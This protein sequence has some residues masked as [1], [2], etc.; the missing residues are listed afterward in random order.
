MGKQG[1]LA[2][3]AAGRHLLKDDAKIIGVAVS[4]KK[5][6][7]EQM[8]T[9]LSNDSM[10]WLGSGESLINGEF[11]VE[12]GYFAPGYEKPNE[13][14]SEAIRLLARTEGLLADPVYTGKG[15]AGMLGQIRQGKVKPGSTVV[16]WHTGGA[17]ALFA[18]REILGSL[19]E[20]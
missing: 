5:P 1:T 3:L 16:F 11:S 20:A 19:V 6:E 2:G 9:N 7:Y 15:L 13:M 14:A 17:T 12:R 10:Q 18:E 8:C 4:D